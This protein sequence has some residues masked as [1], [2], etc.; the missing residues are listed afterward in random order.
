MTELQGEHRKE[1]WAP[2][3]A[4][5]SGENSKLFQAIISG[6]SFMS[7]GSN[8][9]QSKTIIGAGLYYSATSDMSFLTEMSLRRRFEALTGGFKCA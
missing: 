1:E 4:C 7:E 3:S 5:V 9:R 6:G 2:E 8:S